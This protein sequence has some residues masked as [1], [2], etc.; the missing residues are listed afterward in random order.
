MRSVS[1]PRA[2]I[3]G[4]LTIT[5]PVIAA[6]LVVPFVGMRMLGP[7]VGLVY[8]VFAAIA[9]G[10]Q[11]YSIALPRWKGWLTERGFQPEEVARLARQAGLAW[12]LE[13][14]VGPFA[15]HTTAAV[16]CGNFFGPWLLSRW[17][18]WIAPLLG[19]PS[20]RP[21]GNDWLQHFELT[22]IVPALVV[23]Y[24]LS[25][26]LRRLS[27]WAWIAPTIILAYQL[28]AFTDPPASVLAAP[29]HSM[30]WEYFFVIQ[31]TMPTFTPGFGGVDPIRVA[32]QMFVISPFYA[33]LAYSAGAFAAMH[34]LL[35]RIFPASVRES[36][37]E[38]AQTEEHVEDLSVPETE[39][40]ARDGD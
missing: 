39:G 3:V 40:P 17:D 25:K 36:E 19:M 2:M 8:Y 37:G 24:L 18:L 12:P 1:A 27:L 20:H 34:D 23:G 30:R 5:A 6:I 26:H 29:H 9:L 4:H 32:A 35:K 16:V 14:T 33:G 10:W 38:T 28:W 7:G 31:R 22:S 21:T 15:F 11:W 13:S